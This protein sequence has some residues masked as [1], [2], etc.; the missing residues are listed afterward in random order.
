M[1][2]AFLLPIFLTLIATGT[3]CATPADTGAEMGGICAECHMVEGDGIVPPESHWA[4][5]GVDPEHD[6]CTQCHAG[7]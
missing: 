5:N 6:A 2:T 7:H 4:G 3:G 1:A